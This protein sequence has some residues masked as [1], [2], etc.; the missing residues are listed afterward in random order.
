MKKAGKII[1]SVFASIGII[2]SLVV[3]V[4]AIV[5]QMAQ[6]NPEEFSEA[7]GEG[8]EQTT[9]DLSDA[10]KEQA[11][12]GAEFFEEL[13]LNT[14][15]QEMRGHGI[16]GALLSLIVLVTV[17]INV[18]SMPVITPAIASLAAVAG[19][20]FCG[21]AITIVMVPT[22]IGCALVL[23]ASFGEAKPVSSDVENE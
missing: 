12:Q 15:S 13:V 21:L 18:S 22:L 23:V 10:E 14:D 17:L 6:E 9:A 1:A 3:F 8:M 5:I 11:Q 2:V 20:L 4:T 19:V 7:I 16:L